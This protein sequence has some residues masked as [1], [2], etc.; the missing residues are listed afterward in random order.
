MQQGN[1]KQGMVQLAFDNAELGPVLH[2]CWWDPLAIT[3]QRTLA[4][5]RGTLEIQ[6]GFVVSE[7]SFDL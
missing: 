6:M 4:T 2:H 7:K 3:R 1:T 5:F